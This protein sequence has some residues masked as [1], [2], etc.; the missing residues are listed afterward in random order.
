VN[1]ASNVKRALAFVRD[2]IPAF[3]LKTRATGEG[4]YSK[5]RFYT[6]L[7]KEF[8][9]GGFN[10]R[11]IHRQGSFAIYRQTWKGDKHSAAF[12]VIRVRQ[13]DCFL[14]GGRFVE[15]AEIYPKSEAWGLDGFTFT[16]KDAAFEKLRDLA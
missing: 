1:E 12:E 6:P 14:I 13:R 16:E 3:T 8:R 10:Y 5:G 9:R 4:G 2:S 11:Q 15:P 7:A